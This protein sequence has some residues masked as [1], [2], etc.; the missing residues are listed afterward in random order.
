MKQNGEVYTH[1]FRITAADSFEITNLILNERANE[2]QLQSQT[3][4]W[5]TGKQVYNG[6]VFSQ[7]LNAVLST[8]QTFLNA[9]AESKRPLI[10]WMVGIESGG[11]VLTHDHNQSDWS[12]VFYPNSID[13]EDGGKILFDDGTI[14]RPKAGLLVMFKG[15]LAHRVT[16]Y[17]GTA[18]RM[19]IAFNRLGG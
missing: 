2:S 5:S 7:A 1:Q 10:Y 16:K 12:G 13:N 8:V 6:M 18:P 17:T 15:D 9:I 19:S 4:G 3:N 11:R 14:I